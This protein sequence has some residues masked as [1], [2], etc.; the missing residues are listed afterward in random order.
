MTLPRDDQGVGEAPSSGVGRA[1][2]AGGT[3]V[4][5]ILSLVFAVIFAP[6]GII[7]GHLAKRQIKRTGQGGGGLATAGLV[8]GYVV[9]VV[10]VAAVLIALAAGI[11]GGGGGS[12][13]GY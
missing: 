2:S 4:L 12:G 10:G 13:G 8:I 6:L 7:L 5:A 1:P 9:L 3:N 11:G